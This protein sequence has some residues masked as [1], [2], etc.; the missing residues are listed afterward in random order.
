M[1]YKEQKIEIYSSILKPITKTDFRK[2]KNKKIKKKK[3][4]SEKN[5]LH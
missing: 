5:L 1:E 2:Q 4:S 3:K